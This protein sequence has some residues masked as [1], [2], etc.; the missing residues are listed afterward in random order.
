ME[1]T[2]FLKA[3]QNDETESFLYSLHPILNT[4]KCLNILPMV[5]K[6][7]DQTL[8]SKAKHEENEHTLRAGWS[9]CSGLP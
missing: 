9:P 7:K 8:E 4:N 2:F 1:Y 6:K 3:S 5:N